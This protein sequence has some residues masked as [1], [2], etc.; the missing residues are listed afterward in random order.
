MKTNRLEAFENKISKHGEHAVRAVKELLSR[1]G[2]YCIYPRVVSHF[3]FGGELCDGPYAILKASFNFKADDL[4]SLLG[5]DELARMTVQ[6][7]DVPGF[8]DGVF[9][10]TATFMYSY[11]K[12]K[13]YFFGG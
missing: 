1:K 7:Y 12:N 8:N 4:M 2:A 9:Q 5:D 11:K 3:N 13:A 10:G 6:R